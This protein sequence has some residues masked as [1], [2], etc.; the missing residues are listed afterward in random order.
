MNE[1]IMYWKKKTQTHKF[2][3][4]PIVPSIFH[5]Q[6]PT[7]SADSDWAT[8]YSTRLSINGIVMFL[9]GG[10][11]HYKTKFQDGIAHSSAEAEFVA[12]C[13]AA[14]IALYMVY[15]RRNRNFTRRSNNNF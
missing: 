11:I 9:A 13:E 1:G 12:A 8:D 7:G 14:K 10:T 2:L 4:S 5:K 3:Q 6:N 15:C